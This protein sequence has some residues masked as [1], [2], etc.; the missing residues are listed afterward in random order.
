MYASN[1]FSK[2]S[3][4]RFN[5]KISGG[6]VLL[7]LGCHLIDLLLWYFGSIT[8]VSGSIKSIYSEV[9]DFAHA[10]FEFS[11]NIKG[12]LDT[13]WSKEGFTIPEVNL[14]IIGSN[15]W[16]KV[17]QDYIEIKLKNPIPPI[18]ETHVKIY[19]QELDQGVSFDV[20][21]PDYTK[22]DMHIVNSVMKKRH[23]I[24]DAYEASKTQSVLQAIYDSAAQNKSLKVEYFE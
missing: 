15:G 9:E 14:E 5:K 6:G 3:G 1:I 10:E 17:N 18:Q 2:P 19:K 12:E 23:T 11:N 24:I 4:W 13:S 8:K 20:A 21:G 7:E 16:L 22:E